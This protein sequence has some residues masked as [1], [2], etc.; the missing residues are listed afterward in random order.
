LTVYALAG[1]IGIGFYWGRK[2]KRMNTSRSNVFPEAVFRESNIDRTGHLIR[3][4]GT[5]L[6]EFLFSNQR[7]FEEIKNFRLEADDV[8]VVSFPKSGTTWI[9]E[10]IYQILG[11]K[12]G[13]M[14]ERNIEERFPYLEYIYPGVREIQRQPSPRLI[15]THLP[16]HLLPSDVH[17]GK[18]KVVYIA[19]NAKDVCVSY[20]HFVRMLSFLHYTGDFEHFFDNFINGTVSSGPWFDHVE[21]F[22]RHRSDKNVLFVTYEEMKRN[23]TVMVQKVADFFNK[24]LTSDQV[25]EIVS[26]TNFES[27]KSNRLTNYSWWDE[28]GITSKHD[29][30]RAEFMRKGQVGDWKNHMTRDMSD[31]IERDWL[32]PLAAR[33]LSFTD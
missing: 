26:R 25:D 33:G 13:K 24:Q 6:S 18:G 19:R 9:Q 4:Q 27:M 17:S 2:R 32:E 8:L 29:K 20:Y 10:V 11:T 3:Y 31:V 15:K 16:F 7:I 1:I 28:L 5:W 23:P 30:G 14:D 12:D 22:W 21:T